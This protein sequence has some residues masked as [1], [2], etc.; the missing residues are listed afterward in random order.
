M[1]ESEQ[2]PRA[3]FGSTTEAA[4]KD[5]ARP[6]TGSARPFRNLMEV[7]EKLTQAAPLLLDQRKITYDH[8]S[9]L[10]IYWEDGDYAEMEENAKKIHQVFW[11]TY[12]YDIALFPLL[13]KFQDPEADLIGRL[14]RIRS[15]LDPKAKN[16]VIVYYCGHGLYEHG[17]LL[18]QPKKTSI[19]S[20]NWKSVQQLLPEANCDW[21]FVFDCCYATRMIVDQQKWKRRCEILGSTNPLDEAPADISRSFTSFLCSELSHW[22][23]V[24]GI[25][26]Q[27]LYWNLTSTTKM[28]RYRLEKMPGHRNHSFKAYPSFGISI[29]PRPTSRPMDA[30]AETSGITTSPQAL[31]SVDQ[32]K[33]TSSSLMLIA[34]HLSDTAGIMD[35]AQWRNMIQVSPQAIARLDFIPVLQSDF[36]KL[37][38]NL[39]LGE[40]EL[41]GV[42]EGSCIAIITMPIW[43]WDCVEYIAAFQ[44]IAVVQSRNL[45]QFTAEKATPRLALPS[46]DKKSLTPPCSSFSSW[47]E[48]NQFYYRLGTAIKTTIR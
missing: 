22:G 1:P 21:L 35:T 4:N 27:E 37:H 24:G 38:A 43:L 32:L 5:S 34:A 20:A 9:G 26:V 12:S 13:K 47:G 10:S 46:V 23:P 14:M 41:N 7:A 36:A 42:F 19:R 17:K 2:S 6:Y 28:E 15:D 3:L 45:L 39:V 25:T 33:S 30:S 48:G 40:V 8:V 11:E 31:R 44:A 18:W 29:V 16:L